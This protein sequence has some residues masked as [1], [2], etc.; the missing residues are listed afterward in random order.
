MRALGVIPAR[1]GSTRLPHK[2]LQL[3]AGEP[4]ITRVLERVLEHRVLADVVVAT[5]SA[6][7][8]NIVEVSRWKTL[9]MC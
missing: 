3:L 1:L 8:A 4:L 2:P 5:D 7:V 9:S 6:A